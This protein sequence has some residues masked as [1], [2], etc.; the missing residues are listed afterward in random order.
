MYKSKHL[1]NLFICIGALFVG[2][3]LS[4]GITKANII[5][6]VKEIK[7]IGIFD[8]IVFCKILFKNLIVGGFNS[9]FGY[10]TGGLFSIVVL[11]WNG[12][13]IGIIIKSTPIES[14][15]IPY[16]IYHGFFEIMEFIFFGLIGLKCFDF[17][18]NLFKR[19]T[20]RFNFSKRLF[21]F[22]IIVLFIAAVIETFLISYD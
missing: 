19:D 8:I 13:L 22:S 9:V 5:S 7:H 14:P 21:L 17:F 2:F 18:V 6:P 16:F 10:F 3:F 1:Y 15:V 4:Y 12:M 11:F 20:I